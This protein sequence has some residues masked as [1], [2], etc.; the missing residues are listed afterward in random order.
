ME[1]GED[2]QITIVDEEGNEI[3][4]NIILTFESDD[5]GKS[6]VIYSPVGQEF[7]EDGDPIYHASSFIPAEDGEDGELYPIESDEEWEMV[8][9]VLNTFFDEEEGE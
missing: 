2:R 5:Y 6:Y 3:L 7:D 1:H 8:E 4:C 9:E